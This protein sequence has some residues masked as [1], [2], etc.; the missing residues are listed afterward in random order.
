MKPLKIIDRILIDRKLFAEGKF[1]PEEV[2]KEKVSLGF[3]AEHF[4]VLLKGRIKVLSHPSVLKKVLPEYLKV[5]QKYGLRVFVYINVHWH[6]VGDLED[7]PEWFQVD[8][9]GKVITNVYGKGLMPCVNSPGWREYSLSVIEEVARTGPYGIFLDGPVFHPRGCYCKYCVTGFTSRYGHKPPRKGDLLNKLHAEL[10]EFQQDSLANYMKEAYERVKRVNERVL[11]YL[12]G[13]PLRPSWASGRDNV[14]LAKYQD[15]VGAEG[16]FEYYNLIESP[17]FKCSMTAKLLEAQAPSKPRV[18]FIAAKHS[19]WNRE[20]LTPAELKLRCAETLA[21]GAYYW[22]GYTWRSEEL[23]AAMR[24]INSWIDGNEDYF[25]DTSNVARVG[26]YWS[27]LTANTYGGEVP[28][29]DFTGRTIRF[30]RDYMKS[31]L[32]AY[33][34]LTRVRVPFRIVISPE[35]LVDL[36]LIVLPNVACLTD[37]EVE[38]IC[39]FVENGGRLIASFESSLYSSTGDKL[40]DFTLADV[41]GVQYLGI[42]EYGTYENYIVFD[43]MS[44]PAYTY[45]IKVKVTSGRAVNRL[46][47]NTKGWYQPLTVSKYPGVVENEYGDG[48]S[49]YF[50]GNFFQTFSKYRFSSYMR[51]FDKLIDKLITREVIIEGAPLSLEV[52]LR[53]KGPLKEIHLV[54]FTSELMRPI[55][56]VVPLYNLTIKLP[57]VKR[58]NKVTNLINKNASLSWSIGEE[59]LTIRLSELKNYE[60]ITVK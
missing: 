40:P 37:E 56:N 25:T 13:E 34:L 49:V 21:N 46:T 23:E 29:S 1:N 42:E 36:D 19:P 10:V 18:I 26:L 6:D 53:G 44:I 48:V 16:G 58:T 54:N 20:T 7:H 4:S 8:Y 2:I 45:V 12:N 31:F 30:T 35:Q 51:Y 38:V 60:V 43:K 28:T 22:I 24:E 14:K 5:A 52:T 59:G 27:Q 33:E 55:H 57:R 47:E 32:G 41:F 17:F 11:I 9:D 15:L 39:K 50:A 3:N